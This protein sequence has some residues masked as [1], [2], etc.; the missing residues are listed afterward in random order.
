LDLPS[1]LDYYA[2]GRQWMLS[3]ATKID[4]STVDVAGSNANLFLGTASVLADSVTKQLGY[5]ASALTLDGAYDDDLDRYIWDR[6]QL[7]RKGASPAL[8]QLRL[9]RSAATAGAGTVAAGTIVQS[10]GG[11]EYLTT[12]P[13]NFGAS[14]LDQVLVNASAVQAGKA[15]Q[16]GANTIRRFKNANQLFDPTIQVNNDAASAGGEDREDDDTVKARVRNF[17]TTARRGTLAAI[18]FGALSVPG[19]VSAMAVEALSP[20]GLPARVVNLYI[21]DSSGVASV[22]LAQA[23]AAQLNDYRAAGI[24]VIIFTSIPLI[25]NIQL[26]LSYTTGIDTVTLGN[27]V[28]AAVV[29]FVNSLPVNGP[30]YLFQLGTVLQRF[31]ADGLL[32]AQ[33]G[34]VSPTGDVYPPLGQTIR[35]TPA[36]VTL[37]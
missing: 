23:V 35:T 19:V 18:E 10:L 27:L 13:G 33:S 21:A 8:T 14:T 2:L 15:T 31:A 28:Q 22:P 17:W 29:E 32:P 9:Y 25:Q 4:P 24:A 5:A 16:V 30:L 11:V 12:T 36:N 3:K 37:S 7:T 26:A 6:Y 20:T 34:I 1:R